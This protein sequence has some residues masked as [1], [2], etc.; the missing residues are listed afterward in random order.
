MH[1]KYPFSMFGKEYGVSETWYK[2]GVSTSKLVTVLRTSGLF[3][4]PFF[5]A[6]YRTVFRFSYSI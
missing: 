5:I 6:F 3:S 2:L 1:D 4:V